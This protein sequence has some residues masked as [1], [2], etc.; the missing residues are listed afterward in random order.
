M[1]DKEKYV[2][3]GNVEHILKHPSG[4]IYG[5]RPYYRNRLWGYVEKD[6]WEKLQKY[7]NGQL[8]LNPEEELRHGSLWVFNAIHKFRPVKPSPF[9]DGWDTGNDYIRMSTCA[10]YKYLREWTVFDVIISCVGCWF[11]NLIHG[12]LTWSAY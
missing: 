3:I 6:F 2:R 9:I 7:Q 5:F 10:G 4:S 1:Y 8:L 11:L 12:R